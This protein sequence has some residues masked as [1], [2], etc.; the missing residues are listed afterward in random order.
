VVAHA[1]KSST[2]FS[3]YCNKR[4]G[5]HTGSPICLGSLGRDQGLVRQSLPPCPTLLL[6]V[7]EGYVAVGIRALMRRGLKPRPPATNTV[8]EAESVD[9]HQLIKTN[10]YILP[11]ACYPLPHDVSITI[12]PPLSARW[13]ALPTCRSSHRRPLQPSRFSILPL[14]PTFF[15]SSV[16]IVTGFIMSKS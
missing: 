8:N 10:L 16:G 2:Q 9:A 14:F 3:C 6:V 1:T 15:S 13:C 11:N 4:V 5:R 12:T 7:P